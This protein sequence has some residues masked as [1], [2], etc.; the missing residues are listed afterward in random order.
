MSNFYGFKTRQDFSQ[1]HRGVSSLLTTGSMFSRHSG[2]VSLFSTA[3]VPGAQES[4]AAR[5]GNCP[6]N[7]L[8]QWDE[9][10]CVPL[11]ISNH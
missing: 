3:V 10:A 9:Y 7:F 11:N 2:V 1:M 4:G 8:S 5:G 6:P